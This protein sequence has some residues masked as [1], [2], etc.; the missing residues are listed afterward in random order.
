MELLYFLD[1]V[2]TLVFAISGTFAAAE[3]R[4]DWFGALFIAMVTAVGGGTL[5]DLLIG[6]HPIGWMEDRYAAIAIF[7]AWLLTLLVGKPILKFRKTLFLFDTIGI[8]VFT[9]L[10]MQKA[11]LFGLSPLMAV[12]LGMCSATMGGVARDVLCNEIPL[13]FR[14]EI[15]ATACLIG[16]GLYL[17]LT[18]MNANE[19][20][21]I[22]SSISVIIIVRLISVKKKLSLPTLNNIHDD[23]EN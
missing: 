13:I 20:I 17:L 12:L 6:A 3:K 11:L 8:G 14:K 1:V 2:G 22:L 23:G 4:L 9:I 10:G 21:A 7:V 19:S 16:A 5:R 15:Y 18:K